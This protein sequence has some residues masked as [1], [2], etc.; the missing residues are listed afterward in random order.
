MSVDVFGR[1]LR[2]KGEKIRGPPSAGFNFTTAGHFDIGNKKLCNISEPTEDSDAVNLRKLRG[3]INA[4]NQDFIPSE[5]DVKICKEKIENLEN[6]YGLIAQLII[7]IG[8]DVEN[9]KTRLQSLDG[10]HS[11]RNLLIDEQLGKKS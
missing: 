9:C 1:H 11:Q 8:A 4:N 3:E 6:L 7:T 5:N 10:K 2:Q